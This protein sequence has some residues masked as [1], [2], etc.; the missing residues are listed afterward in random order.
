MSDERIV[1]SYVWHDGVCFFVSTI[2]RDSSG[3]DGGRFNETLVW[4]YNWEER[5]RGKLIAQDSAPVGSINTH[6]K[7]VDTLFRDGNLKSLEEA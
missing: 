4:D 1:K 6:Q 2:E 3:I 7:I 5:E